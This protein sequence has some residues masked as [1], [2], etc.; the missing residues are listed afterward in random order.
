MPVQAVERDVYFSPNEPFCKRRF[1][2]EDFFPGREPM[3]QLL[4]LAGPKLF[5]IFDRLVVDLLVVSE[6]F[7]VGVFRKLRARL[8]DA[9]LLQNRSN[10]RHAETLSKSLQLSIHLYKKGGLCPER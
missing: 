3:Q 5:R 10:L 7:D 9:L 4:G 8:E 2:F 6:G 1:P